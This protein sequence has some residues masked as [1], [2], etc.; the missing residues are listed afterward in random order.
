MCGRGFWTKLKPAKRCEL[1]RSGL[2]LPP[3]LQASSSQGPHVER[4]SGSD[5]ASDR[6]GI[7]GVYSVPDQIISSRVS[8]GAL[9][10][11]IRQLAYD[12]A[13]SNHPRQGE[14]EPSPRSLSAISKNL[15]SFSGFQYGSCRL[16]WPP[17]KTL[18]VMFSLP[19]PPTILVPIGPFDW[20]MRLR[21][22]VFLVD[23][24]TS[25][26]TGMVVGEISAAA[27]CF[28]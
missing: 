25:D 8:V 1:Q 6:R 17:G 11:S 26:R 18:P 14:L 28:D 19:D 3:R 22:L 20:R 2:Q 16:D 23:E 7:P 9:L 4:K 13:R 27:A 5:R 15:L 12:L 10:D 24:G 21:L